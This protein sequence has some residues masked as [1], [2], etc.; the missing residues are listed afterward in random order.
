MRRL[1][2]IL[3]LVLLLVLLLGSAPVDDDGDTAPVRFLICHPGSQGT[4]EQAQ[5]FMDSFAR[6][7]EEASGLDEGTIRCVYHPDAEAGLAFLDEEKPLVG[8]VSLSFYLRYR[9]ERKLAP[10]LQVERG[11]KHTQSFQILARKGRFGN[12]EEFAGKRLLSNHLFDPAFLER[13]ILAGS[14]AAAP[15]SV[16]VKRPLRAIRKV[17]RGDEDGVLVDDRQWATLKEMPQ[18]ADEVGVV[19]R[20]K[21]LPTEPVVTIGDV[22]KDGRIEKIREGLR[23]LADTEKGAEI[24]KEFQMD[25]FVDA[26]TA[27]YEGVQKLYE[28]GP[29]ETRGDKP[30]GEA[31][32][33]EALPE[34]PRSP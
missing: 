15:E 28:A 23:K 3:P 34:A 4:T 6:A 33:G 9:T 20:S 1:A 5:P 7:L 26:D 21:D 27:A 30:A 29:A 25:R 8:I 10:L 17:S 12:L 19:F 22:A 11:G 14:D 24:C 32:T 31:G 13:V 18:I 16:E 2:A